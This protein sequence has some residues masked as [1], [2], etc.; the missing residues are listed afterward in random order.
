M[1]ALTDTVL[2]CV[3]HFRVST[4][5]CPVR[6]VS[7][8]S[9]AARAARATPRLTAPHSASR[10]SRTR[11]Q[12]GAHSH[13]THPQPHATTA[14]RSQQL[15]ITAPIPISHKGV[16]EVFNLSYRLQLAACER[17]TCTACTAATYACRPAGCLVPGARGGARTAALASW[18]FRL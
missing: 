12:R 4:Q 1:S 6:A 17:C 2:R 7:S 10:F 13:R 16:P 5:Q 8:K 14:H 15:T 18:L 3:S 11:T 9:R